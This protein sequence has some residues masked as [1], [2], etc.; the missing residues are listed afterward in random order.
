MSDE[1]NYNNLAKPFKAKMLTTV[2]NKFDFFTQFDEWKRFDEE[3]GYN[4]L[5]LI[6]RFMDDKPEMSE[7]EYNQAIDKA[8]D[9]VLQIDVLDQYK[10]VTGVIT[11]HF[12]ASE[13]EA[14]SM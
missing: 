5:G 2:D 14:L 4:T 3:F 11:P 1:I 9:K 13:E 7:T 10:V 8:I 12:I 6:A